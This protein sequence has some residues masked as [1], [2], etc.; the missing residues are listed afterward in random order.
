MI[1]GYILGVEKQE[2]IRAPI[3]WSKAELK[4]GGFNSSMHS[5]QNFCSKFS[6]C[7]IFKTE[8]Q[9]ASSLSV[10]GNHA[11]PLRKPRRGT[12][13]QRSMTGWEMET[14]KLWGHS[15]GQKWV[16]RTTRGE[17]TLSARVSYVSTQHASIYLAPSN[18][19]WGNSIS[20]PAAGRSSLRKGRPGLHGVSAL[21]CRS[22]PAWS[23]LDRWRGTPLIA[24]SVQLF[25]RSGV[26]T[27]RVTRNGGYSVN[28]GPRADAEHCGKL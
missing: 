15:E 26:A 19:L 3:S 5:S 16:P 27:S 11:L 20:L 13:G 9:E 21:S 25:Y 8:I 7:W 2:N 24:P 4:R 23:P 18:K 1:S 17:Q 6:E 28:D 14:N 22:Y 12:S 10:T